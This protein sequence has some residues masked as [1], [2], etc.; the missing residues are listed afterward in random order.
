MSTP[1]TLPSTPSGSLLEAIIAATGGIYAR[2]DRDQRAFLSGAAAVGSALECPPGCGSCCEPFVPDILPSEAA[3]IAAWLLESAPELARETAAWTAVDSPAV[4]PCPFLRRSG[5]GARCAIYP[6]RP[7]VCRLFGA[8]GTRDKEGL[9]S[10][11]PCAHMP[12][13]GFPPVGGE[14]PSIT[15]PRLEERFGAPPPAMAVYAAELAALSPSEAAERSLIV[16]ALPA[17]LARVSL[18]LSLADGMCDRTYSA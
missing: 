15:G 18:S 5:N 9:A 16:D 3:L 7:L 6:V 11:R 12:L 2:I 14:R 4:P 17:A 8:S 1:D 13:A 10:F